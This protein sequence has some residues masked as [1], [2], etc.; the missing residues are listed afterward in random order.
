MDPVKVEPDSEPVSPVADHPVHIKE[1]VHPTTVSLP[2]K[3]AV[4]VSYAIYPQ[5]QKMVSLLIL[6]P[7]SHMNNIKQFPYFTVHC[8]TLSW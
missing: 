4:M 1:E 8:I 5:T 6:A 7:T 2:I 3:C